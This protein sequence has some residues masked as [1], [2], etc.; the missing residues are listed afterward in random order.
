MDFYLQVR[1]QLVWYIFEW[2]KWREQNVTSFWNSLYIDITIDQNIFQFLS[3]WQ[4]SGH[5]CLMLRLIKQKCSHLTPFI[6]NLINHVIYKISRW[7]VPLIYILFILFIFFL[8]RSVSYLSLYTLINFKVLFVQS[9]H[10]KCLRTHFD[11]IC[12]NEMGI[13]S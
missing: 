10:A 2:I 4:L 12:Q 11:W 9:F 7:S 8:T 1:K 6:M 3:L 13:I 5:R